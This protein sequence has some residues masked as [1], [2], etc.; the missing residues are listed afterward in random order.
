MMG[1]L[2]MLKWH[3]QFCTTNEHTLHTDSGTSQAET[4]AFPNS[5]SKIQNSLPQQEI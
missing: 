5:D 3:H 1:G 4:V 2:E